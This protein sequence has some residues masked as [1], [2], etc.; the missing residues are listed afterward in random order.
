MGKGWHIAI[1]QIS[2]EG[3]EWLLFLT[4]LPT[5]SH[6]SPSG[7]LFCL[8]P[9]GGWGIGCSIPCAFNSLADTLQ[10]THPVETSEVSGRPKV[11]AG[12]LLLPWAC[13]V[14]VIPART[15][16]L[17]SPACWSSVVMIVSGK[18][19]GVKLQL[20]FGKRGVS[21]LAECPAVWMGFSDLGVISIHRKKFCVSKP[22]V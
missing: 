7:H 16:W 12:G 18:E 20:L 21:T 2:S 1:Y 6:V 13:Q 22:G 19:P 11:D 15:S 9:R 8:K 10:K 3:L 5:Y 17:R 4:K 14:V